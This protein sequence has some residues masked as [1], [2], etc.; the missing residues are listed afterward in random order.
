[1]VKWYFFEVVFLIENYIFCEVLL[2]WALYSLVE[3]IYI[4]DVDWLVFYEEYK[5]Y[6]INEFFFGYLEVF[7]EF[8]INLEIV[9][10]NN[11]G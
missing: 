2:I 10:I 5:V 1:M 8:Y 7:Y 3:F 9:F 6:I 4:K 11:D